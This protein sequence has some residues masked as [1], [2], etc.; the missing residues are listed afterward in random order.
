MPQQHVAFLEALES[1]ECIRSIVQRYNDEQVTLQFNAVV[2]AFAKFR[3]AHYSIVR[4][5]IS[6]FLNAAKVAIETGEPDTAERLQKN[7]IFGENGAG[8]LELS[9]L[10]EF[11]ADTTRAKIL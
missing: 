7:N 4:V 11:R 8:G 5:Y 6:S 9:M 1:H 3:A 10:D 2:S